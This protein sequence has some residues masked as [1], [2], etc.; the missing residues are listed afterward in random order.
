MNGYGNALKDKL[1]L[2]SYIM[3]N[4]VTMADAKG[5]LK[6]IAESIFDKLVKVKVFITNI[7]RLSKE[8]IIKGFI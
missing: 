8:R 2:I 4:F 3:A 7:G 1:R 5:L 6:R